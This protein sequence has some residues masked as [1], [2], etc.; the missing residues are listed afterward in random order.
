MNVLVNDAMEVKAV[1]DSGSNATLINY[2][3]IKSLKSNLIEQKSIFKTLGGKSFTESRAKLRL[4]I[5]GIENEL[6]VYVVRN[7][8]FSYDLLLGLDAIEKF[9]LIQDEKLNILQRTEKGEIELIDNVVKGRRDMKNSQKTGRD[10]VIE[11]LTGEYV[12]V[13]Q[14]SER[15]DYLDQTKREKIVDIIRRYEKVFATDKFDLG[16]VAEHEARIKL[17]EDRYVAKKPYRCTFPDQKEI[18]SQITRLLE[19]GLIEESSS[20]FASPVTLAYKKEDGRRTRLCVDF[21]E[22]NKLVVPESQPFPR[23][24]DIVVKAGQCCWFS[25]FDINSAF[26]SIPIREKD[27]KKTA[28]V[29]Q[30]GHFQWTRLPFGLSISLAVF[31]RILS[32]LIRKSNL[33]KFCIN[34]IDDILVFSKTF[35]EHVWHVEMLMRA[36]L[37]SGF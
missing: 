6:E 24:E 7:S 21:R 29:T 10:T 9:R 13:E 11:V 17:S 35:E 19:R 16:T 33:S 30:N 27:R 23:I 26:W 14:F 25:T 15:I 4:K 22:L 8:N 20:P 3:L 34:Y 18:D 28:F 12:K 5:H 31:Q 36:I 37:T 32:N 1:Y 2:D